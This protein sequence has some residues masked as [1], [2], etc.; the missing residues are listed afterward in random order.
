MAP[1]SSLSSA[2]KTLSVSLDTQLLQRTLAVSND[3]D[4]A[5]EAGLALWL[6]RQQG[7]D[8]GAIAP[9]A[10]QTAAI[11]PKSRQLDLSPNPAIAEGSLALRKSVPRPNVPAHSTIPASRRVQR[12]PIDKRRTSNDDETGWLI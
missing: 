7:A 10:S 9:A 3:L 8:G 12:L 2:K 1:S 4:G 5:I 11:S 6:E